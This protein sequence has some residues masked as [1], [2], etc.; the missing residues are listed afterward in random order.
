MTFMPFFL[1]TQIKCF[2]LFFSHQINSVHEIYTLMCLCC[3]HLDAAQPFTAVSSVEFIVA[4][5]CLSLLSGQTNS[6]MMS[7]RHKQLFLVLTSQHKAFNAEGKWWRGHKGKKYASCS[8]H[9]FQ[10]TLNNSKLSEL[11]P[12]NRR[13]DHSQ[14]LPST[15]ILR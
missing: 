1:S 7:H 15:L 10:F 14:I 5:S 2:W 12:D 6:R 9:H 8:F 13:T 4:A 11:S 3:Y